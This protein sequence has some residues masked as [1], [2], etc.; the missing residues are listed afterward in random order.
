VE[1]EREGPRERLSASKCARIESDDIHV[2]DAAERGKE[3]DK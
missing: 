3:K 2:L 1:F